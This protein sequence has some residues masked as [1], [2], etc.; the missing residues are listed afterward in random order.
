MAV[1]VRAIASSH[2]SV[3]IPKRSN[4]AHCLLRFDGERVRLDYVS[5]AKSAGAEVLSQR[6]HDGLPP[7]VVVDDPIKAWVS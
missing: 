3:L 2:Q 6:S 7:G 5:Q 4:R 1:S